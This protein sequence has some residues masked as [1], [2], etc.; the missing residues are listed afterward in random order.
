MHVESNLSHC[1][2]LGSIPSE[3]TTL[4]QEIQNGRKQD[5]PNRTAASS[6]EV[7]LLPRLRSARE[8]GHADAWARDVG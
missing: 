2:D 6:T 8:V 4:P 7:P 5:K 3:S 1:A